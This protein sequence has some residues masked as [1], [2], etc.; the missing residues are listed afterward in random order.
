[1]V[2]G[3]GLAGCAYRTGAAS[4]KGYMTAELARRLLEPDEAFDGE[5]VDLLAVENTLGGYGGTIFP[6]DE[7]RKVRQIAIDAGV[8]I[9]LDG[10]RIWNASAA[11]G[12]P[13]TEWTSH[14]DTM[15]FCLSK[16]LGAPIGSLVCGPAELIR[17]ARRIWILYGGAW[18]QAR[19]VG[20]ARLR[21]PAEG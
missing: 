7:L 12:L 8:P 18:A 14:V 1:V 10:A 15:M 19:T 11:T 9:H 16:G 17:E 4:P 5:V 6:V 3:A 13:V 2:T 20:L 21:A